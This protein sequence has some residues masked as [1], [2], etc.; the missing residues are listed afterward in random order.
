MRNLDMGGAR[1][2]GCLTIDSNLGLQGSDGVLEPDGV[3]L[4]FKSLNHL[5]LIEVRA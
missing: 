2:R 3:M 4:V 1:Y 5:R